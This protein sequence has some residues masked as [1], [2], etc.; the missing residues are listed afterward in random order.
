[1][2]GMLA[3]IH[4]LTPLHQL[5]AEES[6]QL[7]ME[8]LV[9]GSEGEIQ[10]DV[11]LKNTGSTFFLNDV[12]IGILFDPGIT[13]SGMFDSDK[14]LRI[15]PESSE[16][17]YP[18]EDTDFTLS[19]DGS[20][21]LLSTP[22]PSLNDP[23]QEV[24][25]GS[26]LRVARLQL[27]LSYQGQRGA[28]QNLHPNFALCT[29][30]GQVSHCQTDG[31]GNKTGE[32]IVLGG[33]ELLC[34]FGERPLASHYFYGTGDWH[35]GG[36]KHPHWNNHP[37]THP[38][39]AMQAP[40][41]N[42]NV[43]IGGVVT[44][45]A[46]QQVQLLPDEHGQGGTLIIET[47][48]KHTYRIELVANGEESAVT[49]FDMN[50]NPLPNPYQAFEG[51]RFTVLSMCNN[52]KSQCEF[53]NWTD[54]NGTE[55]NVWPMFGPYILP[56]SHTILT[57]NWSSGSYDKQGQAVAP[58]EGMGPVAGSD[59]MQ[60]NKGLGESREMEVGGKDGEE[61]YSAL[62]IAPGGSLTAA[63]VL[64]HHERGAEA[65]VLQSLTGDDAA[66]SLIHNNEGVEITVERTI[67]RW[68]EGSAQH[69]WH[70]IASPVQGMPFQPEFIPAP[71]DGLLPD[72]FDLYHWDESHTE[73]HNG[74]TVAGW[75]IN[76]RGADNYWNEAFES[77]F[78]SGK[79]YLIAYGDPKGEDKQ[80]EYTYGNRPHRFSGPATVNDM[81]SES[82]TYTAGGDY[83]GWHLLGN[84][85]ASALSWAPGVWPQTN[86]TGG[87]QLWHETNASYVPVIDI[88]PA[89]NGF[90]IRSSGDGQL[91]IPSE[92]RVHH[93][94]GWHKYTARPAKDSTSRPWNPG[95]TVAGQTFRGDSGAIPH[96]RLAALDKAGGTAQESIIV[97]RQEATTGYDP[98]LDTRFVPGYAP[99]FYSLSGGQQLSLNSLPSCPAGGAAGQE[100]YR[101]AT[102]ITIPLGFKKNAATQFE[103]A[104]L[105]NPV[106]VSLEL[107]DL[108]TGHLHCFSHQEPYVFPAADGDASERFLLHIRIEGSLSTGNGQAPG[109]L[110]VYAW[111]NTVEVFTDSESTHFQLIDSQGR[112]LQEKRLTG[113]GNHGIRTQVPRG[114]Y[115][116]RLRTAGRE[117][118]KRVFLVGR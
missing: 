57:A 6:Y 39:F 36:E 4:M 69:G 113:I 101:P 54:Q 46:G 84:P 22:E 66:G 115:V 1:M 92:A 116:V 9:Q 108:F 47:A 53:I 117:M 85:F 67:N 17:L 64:N 7:I 95:Y 105:H 37:D 31:D 58:T 26:T 34:H 15:I 50:L 104:L 61:I 107:E 78:L 2:Y 91:R 25:S 12:R 93:P 27:I 82:L 59:S 70:M 45:P 13:G 29:E 11:L 68:P 94:L 56:P 63:R 60:A 87:P 81:L 19:D 41:E 43:V 114:V 97:F 72:W 30:E 75:W 103:I 111:D 21:L 106:G 80:T 52:S 88:I 73:V 118:G 90:M 40:P 79:G 5:T 42:A 49:L 89:M 109:R 35:T 99:H 38:L 110:H 28:F 18:P 32:G 8:N 48:D 44:I 20:R 102:N 14:G 24:L 98:M 55:V 71:P 3:V 96:I 33:R 10:F 62:V 65:I 51:T 16:L 112:V 74:E 83:A 23:V 100:S 86:I 77:T 76:A